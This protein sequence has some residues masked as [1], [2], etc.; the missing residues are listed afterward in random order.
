M[1]QYVFLVLVLGVLVW[2]VRWGW[3]TMKVQK[4]E[5]VTEDRESVSPEAP[6]PSPAQ[7]TVSVEGLRVVRTTRPPREALME[8]MRRRTKEGI[9]IVCPNHATMPIPRRETSTP[10]GAWAIRWLGAVPQE[11]VLIDPKPSTANCLCSVHHELALKRMEAKILEHQQEQA[12]FVTRQR[13]EW[14]TFQRFGLFE[15]LHDHE[16]AVMGH[17]GT[18]KSKRATVLEAVPRLPRAAD[19]GQGS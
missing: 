3:M 13:D 18:K 8:D 17:N 12:A 5:Q 10:F 15:G 6:S 7:A 1:F 2:L 4:T 16:Q 14:M 11:R 9:C 19:G